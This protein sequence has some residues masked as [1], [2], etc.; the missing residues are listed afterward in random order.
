MKL[1]ILVSYY[2]TYDLTI[3]LLKE[4]SIQLKDNVEVIVVDDGCHE[5]RFDKFE[6]FTII[7]LEENKGMSNALNIA[8]EQAKGEYIAFIDSDDMITMDYID[9]LLEAIKTHKEQIITFN[10]FDINQNILTQEPT[11]Y[12]IWKAIYKKDIFPTFEKDRRYENDVPVYNKLMSMKLSHYHIDRVLYLYN[13][14]RVG[15]LTWERLN[16]NGDNK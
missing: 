4:L 7:H 13:F 6:E 12:A 14:Y 2:N 5:E 11:N 10:W 9:I 8:L 15:S 1:S 16:K 3:K